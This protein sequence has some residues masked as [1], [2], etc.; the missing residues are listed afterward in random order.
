VELGQTQT[1]KNDGSTLGLTNSL[2]TQ[3][4]NPVTTGEAPSGELFVTALSSINPSNY[5]TKY[6]L[7][8]TYLLV[9][10]YSMTTT[11]FR[12]FLLDITK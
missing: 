11:G 8:I 1:I 2:K 4:V 5:Y 7:H 10:R 3:G 6:I 12:I 9:F